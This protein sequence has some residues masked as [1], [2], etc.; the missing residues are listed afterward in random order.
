MDC[1]QGTPIRD[2]IVYS[3][4]HIY[5]YLINS[6]FSRRY[7]LISNASSYPAP[8]YI[9]HLPR[10]TPVLLRRNITNQAL[11]V[12]AE[13]EDITAQDCAWWVT[14]QKSDVQNEPDQQCFEEDEC[15]VECVDVIKN[16]HEKFIASNYIRPS[17]VLHIRFEIS[18][19]SKVLPLKF[20]T[21]IDMVYGIMT[22][23]NTIRQLSVHSQ[24]FI[25]LENNLCW[26]HK[27]LE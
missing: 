15:R 12:K 1:T 10:I 5:Q 9:Y 16:T 19:C 8:E 2:V 13:R 26:N 3:N 20:K 17:T 11:N 21:D 4:T 24:Q 27:V 7:K 25:S 22:I 6:I 23:L 18:V 14:R